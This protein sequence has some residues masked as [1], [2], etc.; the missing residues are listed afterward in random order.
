MM[1]LQTNT[2][3]AHRGNIVSRYDANIIRLTAI[4][5]GGYMDYEANVFTQSKEYQ[6]RIMP[7]Y[8]TGTTSLLDNAGSARVEICEIRKNDWALYR[9]AYT[10]V[11]KSSRNLGLQ[12]LIELSDALTQLNLTSRYKELRLEFKQNNALRSISGI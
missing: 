1:N 4:D 5:K 10:N 7:I 11:V 6:I 8:R 9:L 2:A 12:V 3:P